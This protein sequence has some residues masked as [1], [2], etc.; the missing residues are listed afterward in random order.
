M[1]LP[2]PAGGR[3]TQEV[4]YF[5]FDAPALA[6]WLHEGLD[7]LWALSSPGWTAIQDAVADLAPAP[8]LSRYA[9]V[10]IGFWAILLNNSPLGTDVGVVPSYAARE[11]H[12]RAIRVVSVG[13]ENEFPARLIN[14]YGPDGVPPLALERSIVVA[15]DGDKWVFETSGKPF[16]FEDVAAYSRR[17]KSSRLSHEMILDYLRSLGVP[18]NTEPDWRRAIVLGRS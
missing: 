5:D 18:L 17:L 15:R 3:V 2:S 9:C 11:L 1:V 6:D 12:C 10:P 16:A 4:G 8:T 13:D 14:V 7:G